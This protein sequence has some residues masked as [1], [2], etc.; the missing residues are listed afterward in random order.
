MFALFRNPCRSVFE[1][2]AH[3]AILIH[4]AVGV[5]RYGVEQFDFVF[6]RFEVYDD[7]ESCGEVVVLLRREKNLVFLAVVDFGDEILFVRA[8]LFDVYREHVFAV[9]VN[10]D[11]VAQTRERA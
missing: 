9:F 10:L 1:C 2:L 11:V 4:F 5:A 7:L 8:F 3:T 6:A